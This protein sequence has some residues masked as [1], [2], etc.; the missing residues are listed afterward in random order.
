MI[1]VLTIALT[2]IFLGSCSSTQEVLNTDFEK[3]LFSVKSEVLK[4]TITVIL[5]NS[6]EFQCNESNLVGIRLN[7]EYRDDLTSWYIG[8]SAG[9]S[10]FKGY[11]TVIPICNEKN[12]NHKLTIKLRKGSDEFEE[13]I[14][15]DLDKVL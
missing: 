12:M 5:K 1:R 13:L 7:N 8:C 11:L 9:S 4:G 10:E 15:F 3:V 6:N 2:I 14:T